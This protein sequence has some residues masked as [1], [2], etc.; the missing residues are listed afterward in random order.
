MIFKIDTMPLSSN[1]TYSSDYISRLIYS[2]SSDPLLTLNQSSKEYI[3]NSCT[4]IITSDYKTYIII[5]RSDL[6]YDN[7]RHLYSADFVQHINSLKNKTCYIGLFLKNIFICKIVD[8]FSFQIELYE[9]DI[10]FKYVLSMYQLSPLLHTG[11]SCGQY[12][13]DSISNNAISLVPNI[14]YRKQANLSGLLFSLSDDYENDIASF[15]KKEIDATNNT[16]FPYERIQQHDDVKI[17][18]SYIWASLSFSPIILAKH[19]S[20]RKTVR[21]VINTSEL[22]K[23]F[24]GHVIPTINYLTTDYEKESYYETGGY[25]ISDKITLTM[26]YDPFYPNSIISNII[27]QQMSTKG[28]N[29][30]LKENIFGKPNDNDMNLT[31]MYPPFLQDIAFYYSPYFKALARITQ[32]DSFIREIEGVKKAGCPCINSVLS[33]LFMESIPSIPLFKM[34]SIYLINQNYSVF[35]FWACNYH[36]L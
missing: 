3:P 10:Y 22:Y 16:T 11:H 20:I 31:L 27:K 13:I 25:K 5:I 26:G 14:F 7:G 24:N 6:Y 17:A 35:D 4:D 8:E 23:F 18:P 21:D 33:G 2:A 12:K 1:P 32:N 30:V 29:I 9:P 28:I 36:D 34:K 19:Y 15:Y